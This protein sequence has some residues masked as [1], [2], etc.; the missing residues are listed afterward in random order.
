MRRMISSTPFR[1]RGSVVRMKS[2][3]EIPNSFQRF[4]NV[5][6]CRS[7]ITIGVTPSFFATFSMFW[8]CSSVPVSIRT[9]SPRSRK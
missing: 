2:S 4:R 9:S 5:G 6:A 3:F 7:A 8:P 1:C